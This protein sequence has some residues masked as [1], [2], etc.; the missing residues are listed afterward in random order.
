MPD[1]ESNL[2]SQFKANL[3]AIREQVADEDLDPI[4]GRGFTKVNE[5]LAGVDTNTV[6][7]DTIYQ[8][9]EMS[10]IPQYPSHIDAFNFGNSMGGKK[11]NQK[12]DLYKFKQ[13]HML[14]NRKDTMTH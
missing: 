10:E 6:R 1:E 11:H 9:T 4:Y 8:P 13:D 7:N 14:D 2:E 12:V 5:L 3:E